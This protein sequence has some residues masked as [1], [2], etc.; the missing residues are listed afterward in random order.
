MGTKISM[1]QKK[2]PWPTSRRARR[3]FFFLQYLCNRNPETR[4]K[5][6]VARAGGISCCGGLAVMAQEANSWDP[7]SILGRDTSFDVLESSCLLSAP[8]LQ[9]DSRY[10]LSVYCKVVYKSQTWLD[11][12]LEYSNVT[13]F[14]PVPIFALLTWNWFVRTNFRAF[15]GLNKITLKFDGLKTKMN[16]HPVLNFALFSK[17]R[18][19]EI[20]Y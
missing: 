4:P 14:R 16:F 9:L 11:A 20:D 1:T 12:V 15:E 19:Y 3:V 5:S 8:W 7:S 2:K 13:H 17:V 6:S 18:K 10:N